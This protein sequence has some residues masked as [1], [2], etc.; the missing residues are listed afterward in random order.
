[1]D[2]LV[3]L[4]GGVDSTVLLA[5]TLADGR[6][7][8]A[9]HVQYEHPANLNEAHAVAFIRLAYSKRGIGIVVR[10]IHVPICATPLAAGCGVAGARVVPGRNAC[11]LAVATNFAASHGMRR[12]VFGATAHDSADYV[13]C[14]P[15][16]VSAMSALSGAWGVTIEAP[17]IAMSRKQVLQLGRDVGAPLER[18][19]SC[20]QPQDGKPCGR[21]NSCNQ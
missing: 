7:G 19:W 6:L 4:S 5:K 9:L 20:Y 12:V 1:M 14:R 17:L 16:F 8:I 11:L 13:D 18:T 15:E 10:T 21:C 2:T 3:L